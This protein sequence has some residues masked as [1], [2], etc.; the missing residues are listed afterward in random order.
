MAK[1]KLSEIININNRHVANGE[2]E[3]IF[4]DKNGKELYRYREP[5]LV[6]VFAKEI[7]SHRMHYSKIW[8]PNASSGAGAWEDS[9]IDPNE[10]FAAKYILLGASYDENGVPLEFNDIRY[11]TEDTV[12][13]SFEP[14]TLNPGAEYDGSLINGIPLIEPD[15][16]LKRIE[17]VSYESSYQPSGTPLLQNDV[18][19][20]NN[21]V[22]L[23]TTLKTDEYNGFGYT[24]SDY[25]T[26]TEV[27]L[28]GGRVFDTIGA[29][30][31][32]PRKLFLQGTLDGSTDTS[33]RAL[34]CVAN[35]GSVITIDM[36]ESDVDLVKEGDQIRIGSTSDT[37]DGSTELSDLDQISPYYLVISKSVGGRDITLDR[38]VVDSSGTQITGDVGIFRDTLR[39]FSHRILS[40]PIRKSNNI[41]LV[42]RWRIIFN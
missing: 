5:N 29:C 10:E 8:N 23:E 15:R 41:E 11:Y 20:M 42:I 7:L 16:P 14:V 12:S 33:E 2:L 21:V 35:G 26:L 1:Q 27:A 36:S 24:N 13:S 22:V 34:K 17:S 39:I 4:K 9:N 19:A 25:F 3:F 37:L 40:T 6:K 30:N 28:A 31:C 38:A 32:T 18:R